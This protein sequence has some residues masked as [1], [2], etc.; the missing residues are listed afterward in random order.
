MLLMVILGI[1]T[2]CDETAAAVVEKENGKLNILSDIVSSQVKLHAEWGGVV[3][4][5]AAREHLRNIRPVLDQ[6]VRE[7][8][9]PLEK[10][11]ALAVTQGP[12]LIPALLVGTST[13][14]ALSYAWRKPLIGIHHIEGHIYA[15]FLNGNDAIAFPALA[16]V[17]SGGH[18]QIILMRDHLRYEIVGGTRDDAAG[19]AFD[20][21]ARI[22]G[23]GYPGGPIVSERADRFANGTP[24]GERN[25]QR[26]TRPMAKSGDFDFSFS[27]LKTAVL[28]AVKEKP[29]T[30]GNEA[31]TDELCYEFQ[32][33]VIDSLLGKTLPAAERHGARTVLLAGGVSANPELR[34][35]LEAAVRERLPETAFRS[36]E[37]RHAGDNA[38]MIAAA[39]C[40]HWERSEPDAFSENWKRIDA[41]ADLKL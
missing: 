35:R 38:A 40:Y 23:L 17:V 21:V 19:E 22:L 6:A 9:L 25:S 11:D 36:P 33:A 3:P 37:I 1:E 41:S 28:Y 4:N 24:I 29:E 39:A 12:G 20:K 2:S 10:I 8:G 31:L 30:V 14:K 7:S 5:L 15:N 27:G 18:T 13:A 32:E 34:R 26:F 16:L